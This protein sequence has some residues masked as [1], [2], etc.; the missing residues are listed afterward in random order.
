MLWD[1][2][3]V[4][5]SILKTHFQFASH[6]DP[7]ILKPIMI[8]ESLAKKSEEQD[9]FLSLIKPSQKDMDKIVKSLIILA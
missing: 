2:S 4:K 3:F 1:A 8:F 7:F 6:F 5:D 9:I